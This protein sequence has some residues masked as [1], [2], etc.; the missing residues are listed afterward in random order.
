MSWHL[1]LGRF[2]WN[3]LINIDRARRDAG[4]GL[5]VSPCP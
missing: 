4:S 3:D 2:G 1:E 5:L